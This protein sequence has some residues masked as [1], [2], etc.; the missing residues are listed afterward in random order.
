MAHGAQED[1]TSTLSE[2]E[3]KLVDLERELQT[4]AGGP[5]TIADVAIAVAPRPELNIEPRAEEINFRVGDLRTQ[6]AEL[7]A[8]RDQ[9]QST[10]RELVD[11]YGRLV[12]RLQGAN[13]AGAASP[14]PAA[15]GPIAP[16]IS[17]GAGLVTAAPGVTISSPSAAAQYAPAADAEPS[18][19]SAGGAGQDFG[20]PAPGMPGGGA[21]AYAPPPGGSGASAFSPPPAPTQPSGNAPAYAL[22]PSAPAP[23][24]GLPAEAAFGAAPPQQQAWGA[25]PQAAPDAAWG[26][27]PQAAW[28]PPPAAAGAPLSGGLPPSAVAPAPPAEDPGPHFE[29]EVTVDAGP[30]TDITTLST[31]EQALAQVP[32]AEDVYVKSFEGDRA[33]VDLRLQSPVQLVSELK[34]RLNLPITVR[35]AR[36][37]RLSVDVNADGHG[38]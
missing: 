2:L 11:E 28:G 34:M 33:L 21:P 13:A 8:F 36:D 6:I 37:G 22:P 18:A 5:P 17:W 26:A 20:P 12:D 27:P 15:A 30:F 24:F 23:V 31:F 9:L 7:V 14:P 29:G 16:G 4:V 19:F 25:P 35:E 38:L 32:G 3:R 1:V 10:A